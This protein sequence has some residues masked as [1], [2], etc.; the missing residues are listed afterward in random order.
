MYHVAC[1][2]S[3]FKVGSTK[4]FCCGE[5]G[6]VTQ[7][8]WNPSHP[9]KSPTLSYA[10]NNSMHVHHRNHCVFCISLIRQFGACD[11]VRVY[12]WMGE[13]EIGGE[14]ERKAHT[15]LGLY[16][17]QHTATHRNTLQNTAMHCN[18]LQCT[19]T[20]Y[21]ALQHTATC[22]NTHCNI[23]Q[24]ATILQHTTTHCKTLQHSASSKATRL[25]LRSNKSK[26]NQLE[27]NIAGHFLLQKGMTSGVRRMWFVNVR[28][29]SIA[30]GQGIC[31]CLPFPVDSH[32][33]SIGGKSPESRFF[34]QND[35]SYLQS[36]HRKIENETTQQRQVRK[37]W[38]EASPLCAELGF[39]DVKNVY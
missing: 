19:A 36:L 35:I 18:A 20:R 33:I 4:S 2:P 6:P 9:L 5:L 30:N 38:R 39:N 1:P 16:A 32:S 24:H 29:M 10:S 15:D 37:W 25:I 12:V 27:S 11:F 26:I 17:L 7:P 34:F 3:S 31:A 8:S 14:A 23:L 13:R 28:R 22:C 21:Y